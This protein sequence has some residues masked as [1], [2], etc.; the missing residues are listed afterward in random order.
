M[1]LISVISYSLQCLTFQCTLESDTVEWELNGTDISNDTHYN[2]NTTSGTLTI[3]E[4]RSTD[5]GNYTC[6]TDSISLIVKSK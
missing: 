3:Q 6:D 4:V 2:I 5:T 1:E